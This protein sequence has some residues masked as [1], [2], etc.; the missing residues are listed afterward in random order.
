MPTS[1]CFAEDLKNTSQGVSGVDAECLSEDAGPGHE[2][3][4]LSPASVLLGGAGA[5]NS[6]CFCLQMWYGGDGK[7]IPERHSLDW[8]KE[9][10]PS[11]APVF[12]HLMEHC[13]WGREGETAFLSLLPS[14]LLISLQG[15][16]EQ[17]SEHLCNAMSVLHSLT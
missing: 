14:P 1:L 9:K 2:D 8:W 7:N 17:V 6:L 11:S 13:T 15:R 4:K 10:L 3:Y 16:E 12:L 5:S